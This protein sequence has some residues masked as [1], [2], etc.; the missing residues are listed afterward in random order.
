MAE[1][2]A[3]EPGDLP[4][5]VAKALTPW[6]AL[7]LCGGHCGA[8][9]AGGGGPRRSDAAGVARPLRRAARR[10]SS[11]LPAACSSI[12]SGSMR[13]R[14]PLSRIHCASQ[15]SFVWHRWPNFWRAE[16]VPRCQPMLRKC[17][18]VASAHAHGAA[19]MVMKAGAP[20]GMTAAQSIIA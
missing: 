8:G 2:P 17:C 11:C 12:G 3:D 10:M 20:R 5:V 16:V 15:R 6:R 14:T 18:A 1:A 9:G 13:K 19:A 7:L 4:R